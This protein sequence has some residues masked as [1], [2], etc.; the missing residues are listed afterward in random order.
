MEHGTRS[1]FRG[2][3]YTHAFLNVT[4]L[5][6]YYAPVDG[7]IKEARVIQGRATLLVEWDDAAK[8]IQARTTRD[9]QHL[10]ARGVVVAETV[11]GPVAYMPIGMAQISS[12][13][14]S[15]NKGDVL[16]KG[17]EF[18]YFQFGG[19][20]IILVRGGLFCMRMGC[21]IHV[22]TRSLCGPQLFNNRMAVT[23]KFST[24][25]EHDPRRTMKARQHAFTVGWAPEQQVE[26]MDPEL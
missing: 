11:F 18:G 3:W 17:E 9:W 8:M 13:R 22:L 15:I 23:P 20:D 7:E 14:L 1:E 4:D 25:D 2:G 26:V 16:R 10:Q 12:V 24:T 19:S 5:H 21:S 6:R